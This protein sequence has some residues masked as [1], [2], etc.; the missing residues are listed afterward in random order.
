[1][2]KWLFGFC[3]GKACVLGKRQCANCAVDSEN[4]KCGLK[5]IKLSRTGYCG[6][7]SV[8]VVF[9]SVFVGRLVN[10][11]VAVFFLRLLGNG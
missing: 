4:K 8:Q 10:F 2:G 11:H 1:M 9:F 5:N 3:E 6:R 7:Q